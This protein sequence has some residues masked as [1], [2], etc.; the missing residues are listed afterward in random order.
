M[1]KKELE[2]IVEFLCYYN[3]DDIGSKSNGSIFCR[4][5]RFIYLYDGKLMET[6]QVFGRA[7]DVISNEK[8]KAVIE[9]C[10]NLIFGSSMYYELDKPTAKLKDITDY[11]KPN[12]ELKKDD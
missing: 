9:V 6:E 1:R 7:Y 11:Y 10:S 8:H 2:K 3:K 5:L 4:E 12:K